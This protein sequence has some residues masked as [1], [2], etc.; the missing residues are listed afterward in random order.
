MRRAQGFDD[1]AACTVAG[2]YRNN[3]FVGIA[4]HHYHGRFRTDSADK[5][6]GFETAHFRHIDVKTQYLRLMIAR[7]SDRI[8]AIGY[9]LYHLEA[10]FFEQAFKNEAYR[11]AVVGN[12]GGA[13]VAASAPFTVIRPSTGS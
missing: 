3:R 13:T 10:A 6:Q 12:D 1:V 4:S 8:A 5:R 11:A 9:A 2:G 7:S